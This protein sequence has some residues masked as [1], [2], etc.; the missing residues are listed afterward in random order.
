M[1]TLKQTIATC[2]GCLGLMTLVTGVIYPWLTAGVAAVLFPTQRAGSV[3]MV[4]G[5]PR[6]SELLAQK[7]DDP[8][9]F[10]PRPSA[11]DYATLPS[12]ASNLAP[13]SKALRENIDKARKS[14]SHPEL[15]MTSG[16]G[17]DPHI[18]P[19]GAKSQIER[20]CKARAL[21]AT[22][23][24]KISALIDQNIERPNF[25]ILGRERVNVNRLNEELLK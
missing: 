2:L 14:A 3:L 17:L 5:Q 15:L 7:T 24:G 25:G 4:S 10:W 20:I 11:A 13:S 23:C 1:K 6:G 21:D 16:S 18:S 19:E 9:F 22:H 8:N 12:G